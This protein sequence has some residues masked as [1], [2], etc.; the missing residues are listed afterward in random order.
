[1]V[2]TET[3]IEKLRIR[4]KKHYGSIREVAKIAKKSEKWVGM[5]L[6]N[7]AKIDLNVISIAIDVCNRIEQE[8][9]EKKQF[10]LKKMEG[11]KI[12]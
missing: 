5:M 2:L 1:M 8:E 6:M 7:K 12:A 4:L 9:E 10:I 3:Q 11:L